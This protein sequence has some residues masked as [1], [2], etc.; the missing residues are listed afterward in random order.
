[1]I[2]QV[3][4]CIEDLVS[5]DLNSLNDLLRVRQNPILE[6]DAE[7]LVARVVIINERRVELQVVGVDFDAFWCS[8]KVLSVSQVARELNV[9]W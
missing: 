5:I 4:L 1:V 2:H 7:R 8:F 9:L 6:S 3:R